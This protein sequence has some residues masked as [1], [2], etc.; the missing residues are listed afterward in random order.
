M[1]TILMA[2][3]AG[4][5]AGA[6]VG[7]TAVAQGLEEI[8]I[9]GSRTVKT[10]VESGTM[11]GGPLYKS[12]S[13]TYGVSIAGLDLTS[14][15]GAAELEKRVDDSA[16]AVCQEI[17]RQYPEST[18]DDTKCAKLAAKKTMVKAHAM[19][20]AARKAAPK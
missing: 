18:P 13:L 8:T 16:L 6:L 11:T 17:G 14:S 12:F 9:V 3:A 19:I 2:I 10:K 1:K 15:A 7:G 20:A 5:V 4:T